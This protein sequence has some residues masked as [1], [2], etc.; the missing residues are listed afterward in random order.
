MAASA[1][2]MMLTRIDNDWKIYP[3][4]FASIAS[5]AFTESV[6]KSYATVPNPKG[7]AKKMRQNWRR[8]I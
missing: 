5:P 6:M 8:M 1:T 3:V 2:E 7:R 4:T